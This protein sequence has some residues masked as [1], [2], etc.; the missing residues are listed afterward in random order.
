MDTTTEWFSQTHFVGHVLNAKVA[1]GLPTKLEEVDLRFLNKISMGDTFDGEDTPYDG[2][3]YTAILYGN[4]IAYEVYADY[5]MGSCEQRVKS[6]NKLYYNLYFASQLFLKV[7]AIGRHLFFRGELKEGA[8]TFYVNQGDVEVL[9]KHPQWKEMVRD[10]GL[11]L[12]PTEKKDHF[13]VVV[14]KFFEEG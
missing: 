9:Q 12:Q 8:D 6:G 3:A 13:R 1:E 7:Q 11:E 5:H 2:V 4:Q 14:T 10:F